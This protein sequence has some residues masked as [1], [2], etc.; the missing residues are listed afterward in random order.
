MKKNSEY[1]KRICINKT[2][3]RKCSLGSIQISECRLQFNF[4]RRSNLLIILKLLRVRKNKIILFL[5]RTRIMVEDILFYFS[6]NNKEFFVNY[7]ISRVYV[8]N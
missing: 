1:A 2:N 6:G 8:L 3:R 5:Y 7:Y 4:R